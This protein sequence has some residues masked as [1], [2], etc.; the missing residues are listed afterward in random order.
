VLEGESAIEVHLGPRLEGATAGSD[1][2][3]L[4]V[5]LHVFLPN[6]E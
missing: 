4:E 3:I 6:D 5:E 1:K 2:N